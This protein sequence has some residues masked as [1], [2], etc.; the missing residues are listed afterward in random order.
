MLN[1]VKVVVIIFAL[2]ARIVTSQ[3]QANVL[4][5]KEED[6]VEHHRKRRKLKRDDC[7]VHRISW[8]QKFFFSISIDTISIIIN[9]I[10]IYF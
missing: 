5:Q 2:I 4:S 3:V 1:E 9:I 10:I 7:N 6:E 8:L